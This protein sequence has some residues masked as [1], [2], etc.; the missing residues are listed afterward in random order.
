[1]KSLAAFALFA[2][3]WSSLA[4]S[5]VAT[6]T[7]VLPFVENR[8]LC[9]EI[10]AIE[11][12]DSLRPDLASGLTNKVLLR[13]S[14]W[15]EAKS[16]GQRNVE[17]AVKYDLWDEKFRLALRVDDKLMASTDYATVQDVMQ[18][19]SNPKLSGLFAI[20]GLETKVLTLQI[21][22][23][24]NPIARERLDKVRKWV[25]EN[26]AYVPDPSARFDRGRIAGGESNN[27]LF[28][29]IFEQYSSGADVAAIWRTNA[30]SSSFKLQ[31]LRDA[32]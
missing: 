27:S 23:L 4:W 22:M 1:M 14:L 32:R 17:I 16:I 9:A 10:R 6:A 25:K 26:S 13:I 11:F 19:L 12:P 15:S 30:V 5:S 29:K 8:Q 2:I 20:N 24:L 18:F 3:A 21:D 28:N 7:E 31:E